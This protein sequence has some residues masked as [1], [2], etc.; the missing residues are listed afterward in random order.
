MTNKYYYSKTKQALSIAYVE[1]IYEIKE[2]HSRYRKVMGIDE[3]EKLEKAT[4]PY[5]YYDLKNWVSK[6]GIDVILNGKWDNIIEGH[7]QNARKLGKE[8]GG[9]FIQTLHEMNFKRAWPPWRG[10]SEKYK[11]TWKHIWHIFNEEGANK[12]A[13]WVFAPYSTRFN[14]TNPW[15]Y[16]Y[17]GD[18]YVDWI[19]FNGYNFDGESGAAHHRRISLYGLFLADYNNARKNYRDK[20]IMICSTGMNELSYKPRWVTNAFKDTKKKFPGIKALLWWSDYWSHIDVTRF[21]S[22]INSSDASL[23]AFVDEVSDPYFLGAV[24]YLRDMQN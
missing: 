22:R 1:S 10:Q 2:L 19:G 5:L 4:I 13:T 15:D 6:G 24:P 20:P 18:E 3:N 23:Q 16:S 21:D 14:N 12:Y 7:A 11:K 17:P 8:H 9:F